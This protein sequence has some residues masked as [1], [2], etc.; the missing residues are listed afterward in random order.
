[1]FPYLILGIALLAGL[2]LAG[3]WYAGADPKAV[4]KALK[5]T[6]AI[7]G[8]VLILFFVVTGRFNFILFVLP[9][10]IPLLTRLRSAWN[11]AKTFT[12]M[13][14]GGR[15]GQTSE[16]ETRFLRM[17]LDHD[18]GAMSGLVL[19]G[20]FRGRELDDLNPAERLELLRACRAEDAKSAQALEAYLDRTDPDWRQRAG[21]A[22]ADGAG[23]AGGGFDTGSMTRDEAYRILGLEPGAGADA[24]KEAHRRLMAA[25]HPDHGGSTYLAAKINQA[26]DVLLGGA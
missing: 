25:L 6:A 4:I 13:A 3:R 1:M 18:T 12:R 16:I 26:K 22:G 9:L 11:R 20:P 2:I 23:T 15:S 17:R 14:S 21:E 5:W 7:L 8:V 24:V 19:E 10:L